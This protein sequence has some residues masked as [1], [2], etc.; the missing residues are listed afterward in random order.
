[1]DIRVSSLQFLNPTEKYELFK[2]SCLQIQV[3]KKQ[4][5]E[6]NLILFCFVRQ[7]L[8]IGY[9]NYTIQE[10]NQIVEGMGAKEFKGSKYHLLRKNCNHF[11]DAFREVMFQIFS[12]NVFLIVIFK[13]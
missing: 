10:I 11:S 8:F 2:R 7:S 12:F 5:F 6:K 1:M 9:T 3:I 13:I 4:F